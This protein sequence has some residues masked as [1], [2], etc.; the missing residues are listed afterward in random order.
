M[1]KVLQH[2]STLMGMAL[3]LYWFL[4]WY[5]STQVFPPVNHLRR[6]QRISLI[7]LLIVPPCMI[8]AASGLVHVMNSTEVGFVA[9]LRVF[10]GNAIFSGDQG[11]LVC[12][13]LGGLTIKYRWQH[14]LSR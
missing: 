1:D 5:R 10:I 4:V 12:T 7:S 9:L 13:L 14:T 11:F 6:W 8:G 2:S 3:L